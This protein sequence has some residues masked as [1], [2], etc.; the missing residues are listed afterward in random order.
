MP[1]VRPALC[2]LLLVGLAVSEA[3]AQNIPSPYRFI[4]HGQEVG[5]FSGFMSADEGRFGAGPSPGPFFGARYGVWVSGAFSLDGTASLFPT[6]RDVV[7]PGEDASLEVVGEAETTLLQLDARLAFNLTGRRTWHGINPFV[8]VGGGLAFDIQGDQAE[9]R[10]L[11]EENRFDF[12]PAFVGLFGGGARWILNDRV[13]LR[14]DAVITLYKLGNPDGFRG[15]DLG[16][17]LVPED[18]WVSSPAFTL[19]FVYRW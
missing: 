5:I 14:G 3:R 18:E 7:Q 9:D 13:A 6:T 2:A 1:P 16:F 8:T 12:G 4:E 10:V 17:G 11:D 19:S 15:G